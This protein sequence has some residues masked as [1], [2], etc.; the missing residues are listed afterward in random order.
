MLVS[1]AT[2]S[3]ATNP[4]DLG[5]QFSATIPGTWREE[6]KSGRNSS[7]MVKTYYQDGT[8]KGV[9]TF[10]KNLGGGSFVSPDIPFQSRWRVNGDIVDTYDV[11]TGFLGMFP[12][13]QVI[14]DRIISVSPNRIVTRSLKS[15]S[16]EILKRQ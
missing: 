13:G 1:C 6:V 10:Q 14:Q 2:H 3:P 12:K 11:K 15:G 4:G 8:A 9:L 16:V 7:G 5:R